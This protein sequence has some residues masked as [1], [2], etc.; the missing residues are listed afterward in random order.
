[1]LAFLYNKD[2]DV[3]DMESIFNNEQLHKISRESLA[4][5][6]LLLRKKIAMQEQQK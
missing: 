5:E 6:I 3:N 2:M 1:M 4:Q